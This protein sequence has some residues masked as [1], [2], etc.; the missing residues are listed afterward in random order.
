M[1]R[2]AML[3]RWP[4]RTDVLEF[5]RPFPLR[6]TFVTYRRGRKWFERATP[7]SILNCVGVHGTPGRVRARVVHVFLVPASAI[8]GEEG[9]RIRLVY[10]NVK[11]DEDFTRLELEVI[12]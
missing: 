3:R 11:E 9:E 6:G 7:D 2:P 10:P 4:P 12:G 5:A 1:G 8:V